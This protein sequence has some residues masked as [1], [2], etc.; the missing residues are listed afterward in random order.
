MIRLVVV[1]LLAEQ[2]KT[3]LARLSQDID[4]GATWSA[5]GHQRGRPTYQ[6][7]YGPAGRVLLLRLSRVLPVLDHA[8]H[9]VRLAEA[10]IGD[11]VLEGVAALDGGHGAEEELE[12]QDK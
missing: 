12:V 6:V 1:T 5:G 4:Q 7:H 11:A 9:E 10:G 8:V 2:R 3:T